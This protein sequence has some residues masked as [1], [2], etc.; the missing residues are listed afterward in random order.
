[1]RNTRLPSR[2]TAHNRI[3]AFQPSA[4]EFIVNASLC[5]LYPVLCE[6]HVAQMSAPHQYSV[7]EN[8][9]SA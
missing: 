7:Q 1:M 3:A 8:P 2:A 5:V 6:A 4:A 9:L